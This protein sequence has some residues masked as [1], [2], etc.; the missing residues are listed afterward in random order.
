[1][2]GFWSGWV[3]IYGWTCAITLVLGLVWGVGFGSFLGLCTGL[4]VVGL[5]TLGW[6]WM[7]SSSLFVVFILALVWVGIRSQL[8]VERNLYKWINGR[9]DGER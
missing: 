9:P 1:M 3:Q 7:S 2:S 5:L 8:S 4:A 6:T